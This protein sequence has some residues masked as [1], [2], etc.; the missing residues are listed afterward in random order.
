M[1]KSK[2]RAV[3]ITQAELAKLS[4]ILAYNWGNEEFDKPALDFNSFVEGVTFHD[5]AYCENDNYPISAMSREQWVE[6]TLKG[7]NY[8]LKIL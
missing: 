7:A 8:R 2:T 1:F 5:I 4:G 6:L 3:V